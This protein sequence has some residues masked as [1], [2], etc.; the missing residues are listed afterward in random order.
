MGDSGQ[1]DRFFYFVIIKSIMKY[2]DKLVMYSQK[3]RSH[4][5]VPDSAR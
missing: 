3:L 1:K 4:K 2:A 5:K